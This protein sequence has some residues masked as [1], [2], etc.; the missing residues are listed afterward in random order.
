MPC[1]FCTGK[2]GKHPE[3]SEAVGALTLRRCL[4]G[5][6]DCRP[7]SDVS[8][9]SFCGKRCEVVKQVFVYTHTKTC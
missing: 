4:G 3:H 9:T 7:T 8:F 1:I 6:L 2:T 5:P